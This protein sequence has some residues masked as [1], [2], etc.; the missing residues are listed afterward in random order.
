MCV[1]RQISFSIQNDTEIEPGIQIRTVSLTVTD[2][3]G[4]NSSKAVDISIT[5]INDHPPSI[6]LSEDNVTFIE[7]TGQVQLFVTPPNITDL[8]DNPYQ[9]SV[10]DSAYLCLF[11]L[12]D[13]DDGNEWLSFNNGLL[14]N[15]IMGS[16]DGYCL[17]LNGTGTIEEYEEVAVYDNGIVCVR[18]LLRFVTIQFCILSVNL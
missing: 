14:Y 7:D 9:R 12:Y 18:K 2:S 10:I 16:F 5:L 17:L 1:S 11:D 4:I 13:L 6:S 3:F 8:D 15:S